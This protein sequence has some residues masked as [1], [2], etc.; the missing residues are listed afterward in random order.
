MVGGM[1][2]VQS[3]KTVTPWMDRA[4]TLQEAI[5]NRNYTYVT[6]LDMADADFSSVVPPLP[7]IVVLDGIVK[8]EAVRA[9][10]SLRGA[11]SL[12]KSVRTAAIWRSIMMRQSGQPVDIIYS[13]M[14]CFGLQIDPYRKNHDPEYLFNDLARKVAATKGL[15]PAWLNIEGVAGSKIPRHPASRIVP[16]FPQTAPNKA[17]IYTMSDGTKKNPATFVTKFADYVARFHANFITHSHP[18]VISAYMLPLTWERSLASGKANVKLWTMRG[19]IYY[20]GKLDSTNWQKVQAIY[21][22]KVGDMGTGPPAPHDGYHYFLFLKWKRGQWHFYGDGS[23][24]PRG[25]KWRSPHGRMNKWLF[26]VGQGAQNRIKRWQ[27]PSGGVWLD[28]RSTNFRYHSYGIVPLQDFLVSNPSPKQIAWLGFKYNKP[29]SPRWRRCDVSFDTS[30]LSQAQL[31]NLLMSPVPLH[32]TSCH[33][34]T[35]PNFVDDYT[36]WKLT[37]MGALQMLYSFGGWKKSICAQLAKAG[38]EGV[39]IPHDDKNPLDVTSASY[40][41]SLRFGR[42]V[43][44]VQTKPH[45]K[46]PRQYTQIYVLPYGGWGGPPLNAP[47]ITQQPQQP[48]QT[49]TEEEYKNALLKQLGYPNWMVGGNPVVPQLTG[50]GTISDEAY[51][52]IVRPMGFPGVTRG[53]PVPQP[54]AA[55]GPISW[56]EYRRGLQQMGS[57]SGTGGF[58]YAQLPGGW[59]CPCP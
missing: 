18:H 40:Y 30:K 36:P 48:Q 58:L 22:G 27:A 51:N 56:E 38:V 42:Q 28:Q 10:H 57:G 17:S 37:I 26:T 44:Y 25:M 41:V 47:Y 1:S 19:T 46:T 3:V 20:Q 43:I 35:P 12:N 2:A 5:L 14:G 13:V 32:L 49:M 16:A 29:T 15:G 21:I 4:W 52:A 24:R 33:T 31:D 55:P 7:K 45:H 6:L 23:F 53:A 39:M 8:G 59:C 54:V 50:S 11:L 9:R 34:N